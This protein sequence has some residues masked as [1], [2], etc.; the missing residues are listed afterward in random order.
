MFIVENTNTF[1]EEFNNFP[2]IT[3]WSNDSYN[4]LE[5]SLFFNEELNNIAQAT[6]IAE[7]VAYHEGTIES[8][9]ESAFETV[10]EKIKQLWEK[11]KAFVSRVTDR[12]L[13]WIRKTFTSNGSFWSKYGNVIEDNMPKVKRKNPKFKLFDI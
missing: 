5:A 12:L 3:D 2:E 7:V 11:F 13:A 6:A 8:F 9:N 10:K 4:I 1:Q